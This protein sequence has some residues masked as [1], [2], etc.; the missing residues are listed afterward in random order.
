MLLTIEITMNDK[1]YG[2]ILMNIIHLINK[3]DSFLTETIQIL[4]IMAEKILIKT[5]IVNVP[6]FMNACSILFP[7]ITQTDIADN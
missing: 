3:L 2:S 5:T 1:T 7:P 6:F 4:S